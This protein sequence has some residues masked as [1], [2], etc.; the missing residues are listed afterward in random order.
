MKVKL[1]TKLE[2]ELDKIY[3]KDLPALPTDAKKFIVKYLP[4]ISLIAAVLVFYASYSLWH[5]AH[6]LSAV[7]NYVNAYNPYLSK[8]INYNQMTTLV[9]IALTVYI[10][11]GLLYLFAF[12][13]LKKQKKSGWNLI[14]YGL[15]VNVIYGIVV[16]FTAYGGFGSFLGYLVASAIG[17]YFI[18]QIRSAYTTNHEHK[19]KES[20][21]KD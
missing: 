2:K 15:L 10:I 7:S 4:W 17:G 6:Y 5:D 12:N 11:E 13:N 14:Y 21:K 20:L 1:H 16:A 9:W 3:N 18:F 19:S 8:V